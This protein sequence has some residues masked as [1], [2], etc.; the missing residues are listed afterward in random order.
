MNIIYD[1]LREVSI[2]DYADE[3]GLLMQVSERADPSLGGRFLCYFR[4]VEVV[5]G[6]VLCS[7]HGNGE[8]VNDA[9]SDYAS[10]IS[11]KRLRIRQDYNSPIEVIAP[12]LKRGEDHETK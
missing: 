6:C 1:L 3:S 7:V 10:A 5:D 8:T 4:D 2:E 12:K 11:L 9:I